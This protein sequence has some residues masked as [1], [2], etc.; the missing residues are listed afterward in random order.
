MFQWLWFASAAEG[1]ALCVADELVDPFHHALVM[2]LPIQ[3]VVP[4]LVCEHQLH[5]AS[6]RSTPLP[7]FSCVTAERSFL[8]LAGV[9]SR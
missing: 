1:I 9:R 7:A 3:V 4:G 5:L 8:A 6:F 2:L